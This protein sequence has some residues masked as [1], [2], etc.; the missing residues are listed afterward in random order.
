VEFVLVLLPSPI[1]LPPRLVVVLTQDSTLKAPRGVS[2]ALDAANPV[3]V[4]L[5]C[6]AEPL[7]PV[8]APATSRVTPEAVCAL[9]AAAQ[10]NAVVPLASPSGQ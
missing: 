3:V 7:S 8:R 5:N 10:S 6:E 4:P 9:A 1:I 2:N